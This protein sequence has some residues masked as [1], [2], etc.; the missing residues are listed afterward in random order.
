VSCGYCG[1]R[2]HY[3]GDDFIPR[4]FLKPGLSDQ[5]LQG[6]FFEILRSPLVPGDLKRRAV[7][8]HKRR[9]FFPLYW[10][11]GTRGGILSTVSERMVPGHVPRQGYLSGARSESFQGE[12]A[13]LKIEI[14]RSDSMA[15]LSGPLWGEGS[16]RVRATVERMPD[17]RVILGDF[18]Y[19]YSAAAVKEWDFDGA[20]IQD[21]AK[22]KM[23][24][25][26][27]AIL[28]D[29]A[30]SGEVLETTIPLERVLEM[31]VAS[32]GGSAGGGTELIETTA[33]ILYLPLME[34]VFRYG[35]QIHRVLLEEINGAPLAGRLPFRRDVALMVGFPAA[36]AM[37]F[38]LGKTARLLALDPA[39]GSATAWDA[40][41]VWFWFAVLAVV[42]L[43]V[44][45]H[46]VRNLLRAP[47][48]V[49]LMTGGGLKVSA[50]AGPNELPATPLLRFLA[51]T[52]ESILTG[53]RR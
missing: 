32:W 36:C 2:L 10:V 25:A 20:A 17:A 51:S 34:I 41:V 40:A 37:G 47:I 33:R 14:T 24:G 18:S 9:L 28:A 12:E 11:S 19:V 4:L 46:L 22:E 53:R 45:L 43:G 50:A 52:A 42:V 7:V 48:D 8:L 39:W 5:D 1:R 30:K 3:G 21:L 27:V 35:E 31:G 16:G 13:T 44:G 6:K 49:E 15:S 38:I 29:L 26:Q 23:G